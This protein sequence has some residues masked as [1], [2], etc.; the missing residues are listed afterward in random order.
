MAGAE[1]GVA[2]DLL[3][4]VAELPVNIFADKGDDRL[5]GE[6]GRE[7]DGGRRIEEIL[8]ARL[9]E[10]QLVLGAAVRGDLAFVDDDGADVGVVE[11][12]APGYLHP[13]VLA[14]LAQRAVLADLG[15]IRLADAALEKVQDAGKILGMDKL[16]DILTLELARLVEVDALGGRAGVD[17]GAIRIQQTEAVPAIARNGAQEAFGSRRG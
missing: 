3:G 14:I 6:C 10:A 2:D 15:E 11:K 13:D 1:V 9:G 4:A 16:E 5:R 8:K 7:N 17:D 12:V